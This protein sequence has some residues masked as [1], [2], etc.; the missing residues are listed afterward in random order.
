PGAG[1]AAVQRR[2]RLVPFPGWTLDGVMTVEAGWELVR[3]GGGGQASGPAV[4]AGGPEAATLAARLA[5]RG[6]G[7]TLISA[8]RPKNLPEK[9]PVIPGAVASARGDGSVARVLLADGSE[10]ECR[11]LCVES[12]RAPL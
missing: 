12:P 5:E 6:T 10:H 11:M 7:V 9:V 1:P 4:V 3:A 2:E 8:E